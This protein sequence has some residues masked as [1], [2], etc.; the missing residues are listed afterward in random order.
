[1]SGV[2]RVLRN[3]AWNVA[4]EAIGGA[5]FFLAFVSIARYLGTYLFGIFSFILAFVGVLQV[6]ADFGLTNTLVRDM[7]RDKANAGKAF[8]AAVFL[9]GAF[10]ITLALIMGPLA[11]WWA[12]SSEILWACLIICAVAFVNWLALVF[13]AVCRAHEDMGFNAAGNGTYKILIL[14]LVWGAIHLDAGLVGIALAFL[15]AGIYQFAFFNV[16]VHTHYFALSLRFDP[17]YWKYLLTKSY[18]VGLAMVFRRSVTHVSTLLLTA[19]STPHA[20]GLYNA[21]YRIMHVIDMLPLTLSTTLFPPF[22]RFA[23]ESSERLFQA[24]GDAM[25][26]F[27]IIGIPLFACMLLLAPEIIRLAFG[28]LYH[29][30]VPVLQIMSFAIFL[31]FPTSLYIYAL[32]ALKQER[33]YT[34]CA[35]ACLTVDIALG[36]VLIHFFGERGAAVAIVSGELAF[37]GTGFV[38]LRRQGFGLSVLT[39]V[40]KPLLAMLMASPILLAGA[41]SNSA[42]TLILHALAY[43][44]T[45]LLLIVLLQGIRKEEL[46]FLRSAFNR[47]V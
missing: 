30:A 19:L 47:V 35:G 1:M 5:M 2:H 15:L 25:R 42:L 44:L 9:V 45:Y 26:I 12:S 38:L 11:Y 14:A 7:A 34:V 33:L 20:V 24:L 16:V 10:S 3:S 36:I 31:I 43:G 4:S 41:Q 29:E 6:V 8:A 18:Q 39:M 23:K 28:A 13:A 17:H 46:A 27:S 21:A 37:F 22:S 32:S 40:G